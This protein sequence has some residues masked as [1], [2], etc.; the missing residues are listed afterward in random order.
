MGDYKG[1]NSFIGG[2]EINPYV[3]TKV[4]NKKGRRYLNSPPYSES[5]KDYFNLYNQK[6]YHNFELSINFGSDKNPKISKIYFGETKYKNFTA[7]LFFPIIKIFKN[8]VH[9][10]CYKNEKIGE[11]NL[12]TIK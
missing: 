6:G 11:I 8:S 4:V 3:K 10:L 1:Y 7:E 2:P 9:I 5:M 12:Q